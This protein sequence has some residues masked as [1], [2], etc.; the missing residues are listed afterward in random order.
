MIDIYDSIGDDYLYDQFIVDFDAQLDIL[1]DYINDGYFDNLMQNAQFKG[2]PYY[3]R[4]YVDVLINYHNRIDD[5]RQYSSYLINLVYSNK[6]KLKCEEYVDK[7]IHEM[8]DILMEII[9]EYLKNKHDVDIDTL[10]VDKP[11]IL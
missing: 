9:S 8:N 5:I 3:E 10:V 4:F 7:R 1:K 6:D 11:I 2:Y